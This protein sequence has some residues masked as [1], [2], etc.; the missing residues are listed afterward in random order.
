MTLKEEGFL[1]PLLIPAQGSYIVSP[2]QSYSDGN[3][4]VSVDIMRDQRCLSANFGGNFSIPCAV[5]D[6]VASM[7][8]FLPSSI[9]EEGCILQKSL[10][11]SFVSFF[12]T[13]GSAFCVQ[14]H[15]NLSKSWPL[16]LN[17]CN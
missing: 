11:D 9:S 5:L 6:I 15:P 4:S 2:T 12:S 3:D 7:Q 16:S 17:V 14:I 8:A 1:K 10:I 13:G